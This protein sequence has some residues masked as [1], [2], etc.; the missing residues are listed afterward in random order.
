MESS[1]RSKKNLIEVI[2]G[3]TRLSPIAGMEGEVVPDPIAGYLLSKKDALKSIEKYLHGKGFLHI[4]PLTNGHGMSAVVLD[5][6]DH[7]VR[8]SA[9]HPSAKPEHRL[10]LK[11]LLREVIEGVSVIVSKKLRTDTITDDDVTRVQQEL[12]NDGYIWDDAGRDNLGK[13]E[14]GNVFVLDGSVQ[15]KM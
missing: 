15:K 2:R 4:K 12:T 11:P 3:L 8:L 10:V 13:D 6:G 7:V 1:E 5:A 9:M 14:E